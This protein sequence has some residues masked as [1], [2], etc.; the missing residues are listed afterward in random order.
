MKTKLILS[1]LFLFFL[2]ACGSEETPAQQSSEKPTSAAKA[3]TGSPAKP[4][5]KAVEMVV[6]GDESFTFSYNAMYACTEDRIEVFTMSH[7]PNVRLA[8]PL[9]I[10]VGDSA[11]IKYDSNKVTAP[12]A[13]VVGEITQARRDAGKTRGLTYRNPIESKLTISQLPSKRGEMFVATLST[14]LASDK[15]EQVNVSVDYNVKDSGYCA[16]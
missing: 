4:T 3:P 14:V 10:A 12:M 11:L 8:L 9:D 6:T 2:S 15:G 1:A 13:Y 16:R 7:T 5:G